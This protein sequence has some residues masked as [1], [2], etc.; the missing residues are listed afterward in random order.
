[1]AT[2]H[3]QS[4]PRFSSFLNINVLTSMKLKCERRQT[5]KQLHTC[6]TQI[7]YDSFSLTKQT[8]VR[9]H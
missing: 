2:S 9:T 4:S 7:Q 1:M 8:N 3:H 5:F 6:N